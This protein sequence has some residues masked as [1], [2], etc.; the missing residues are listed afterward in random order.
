[1]DTIKLVIDKAGICKK[2]DQKV[3]TLAYTLI[4]SSIIICMAQI[5]YI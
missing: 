2:V 1:M 5:A 4:W 3:E